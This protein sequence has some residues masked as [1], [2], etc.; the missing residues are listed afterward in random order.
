MHS[1]PTWKTI[2]DCVV[3]NKL[4]RALQDVLHAISNSQ[5]AASDASLKWTSTGLPGIGMQPHH[6]DGDTHVMDLPSMIAKGGREISF[7]RE[8]TTPRASRDRFKFSWM[9]LARLMAWSAIG[10]LS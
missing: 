6:W 8:H 7:L 3:V 5:D 2:L 1:C 10:C 4:A 9:V